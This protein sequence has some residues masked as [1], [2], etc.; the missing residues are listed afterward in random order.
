MRLTP[1]QSALCVI[2]VQEKLIPTIPTGQQVLTECCRL[3]EAANPFRNTRPFYRAIPQRTW[4]NGG[5]DC[6][7]N[8]E[9]KA[10]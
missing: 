3:V 10:Y 5:T 8:Q 7:K 2:D 1:S 6:H 9:S 4:T